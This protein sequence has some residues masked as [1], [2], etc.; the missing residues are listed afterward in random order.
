M[1]VR[2]VQRKWT[3]DKGY[4]VVIGR[5]SVVIMIDWSSQG[6]YDQDRY[7]IRVDVRFA[8][9]RNIYATQVT[10][11]PEGVNEMPSM[12]TEFASN[13]GGRPIMRIRWG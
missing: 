7:S 1:L 4:A 10:D 9:A 5:E 12:C 11:A 6:Y 3:A 2:F 13:A 8:I